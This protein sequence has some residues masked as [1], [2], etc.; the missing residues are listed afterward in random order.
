LSMNVTDPPATA[1]GSDLIGPIFVL[2]AGPV[3]LQDRYWVSQI[4][5]AEDGCVVHHVAGG[6][7]S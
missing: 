6:N 2:C 4:P 7:V 3:L 1:G 5:F